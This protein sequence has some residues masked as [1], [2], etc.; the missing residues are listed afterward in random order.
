MAAA[1]RVAL[2]VAAVR[3]VVVAVVVAM[4]HPFAVAAVLLHLPVWGPG[5]P[6][7]YPTVG[8]PKLFL[9]HYCAHKNLYA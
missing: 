6:A 8:K 2:A 9:Q 5:P 7:Q 4:W 1:V 3:V